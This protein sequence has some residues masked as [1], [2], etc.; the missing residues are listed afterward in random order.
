MGNVPLAIHLFKSGVIIIEQMSPFAFNSF[1]GILSFLYV[2]DE[3]MSSSTFNVLDS[4]IGSNSKVKL[5]K[6]SEFNLIML[7]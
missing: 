5:V 1:G 3:S 2:L 7:G 4:E 6:C